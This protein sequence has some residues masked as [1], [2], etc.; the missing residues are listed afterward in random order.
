MRRI[1]RLFFIILL[2]GISLLFILNTASSQE[3][4]GQLFEKALYLEEVKGEL[5][6]AIEMYNQIL[7]QYPNDREVRVKAQL[8]IGICKEKLGLKEAID[9]YQKVIDN[10]PEFKNEVTVAKQKLHNIARVLNVIEK[11]P[12]FR[13]IQIPTKLRW[14]ARLSPNGQKIA[15]VTDENLWIMPL[16]GNLGPDFPGTPVKLNTGDLEIEWCGLAWSGDGKWIAFN[17]THRE[18]EQVGNQC[19]YM[20]SSE[21]GKP[22]KIHETYRDARVINYRMSL[23]P[24]GKTLAFSS[25][26][27]KKQHIYTISTDGGVPNLLVDSLAREPVFSPDGKM[28]AY[29]EDDNNGRAGGGLWVVPAEGGTPKLVANAGMATSPIW[30]PG[31]DMLAFLDSEND[32]GHIYIIPLEQDGGV[33]GEK[34]TIDRPEEVEGTILLAGW[35]PDNKIGIVCRG[36]QEFALYTLPANGGKAAIIAHGGYPVQPRWSPNGKR[37]FHTNNKNEGSSDWLKFEMAVVSAEGGK[38]TSVPIQSD[39][40]IFKPAWGG[41]NRI[42]P[43]GKTIVFAAQTEKDTSQHWQIW[44]LPVQGGKPTQL[45][46]TPESIID[47]YP[48]WSPDGKSIAFLRTRLSKNYF[49]L[50]NETK[51][52][53]IQINGGEPKPLT[54]V[55]DSVSFCPIAWSPDGK[56]IAYYSF[57]ENSSDEFINVIPV[58][59]GE[60][61]VVGKVQS[62]HVNKELAWSQDSKRIAFNGPKYSDKIVRVIS[63]KDG[64]IVNIETDLVDTNIYH[65]D[66]SPDGTKFVFGGWQGGSAELWLMED[67]LPLIKGIK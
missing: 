23:S 59:G 28:I 5:Q 21:G 43:D 44:T 33:I 30:S 11:K 55:S 17:E 24:Q 22:I 34:I 67:F 50:Y 19:I 58:N 16:L 60:A 46:I 6:S 41:G 13:K 66:W 8:H 39:E 3:T 4:A 51:I 38:V 61:R 52:Y 9:A 26:E 49:N 29:V 54:S 2:T 62:V 37:I 42:S 45:T 65:L 56:H 31:G 57:Y 14:E 20:A 35:T 25:V 27:G 48:C 63:V 36:L 47:K 64:S 12:K 32:E 40:K 18:D 53:I 7:N 10:Y 15:L 1:K